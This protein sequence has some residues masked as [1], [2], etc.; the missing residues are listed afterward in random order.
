MFWPWKK[1]RAKKQAL[2]E[3]ERRKE[4]RL[5]DLNDV[6][7]EP[8]PAGKFGLETKPY[9]ART[10]DASASG[11]KVECEVRFP[12]DTLLSIKLLSPKTGKT[13]QA[14][15]IVRWVAKLEQKEKYEIGVEFVDTPVKT[16][17][18]LL[19]HIYKA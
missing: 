7:V 6:T 15:G 12:V 14:A 18:N 17:M 10:K 5:E 11:L 4:P 8:R 2:F 9:F 16:I 19:E 1:K 13:I 3:E